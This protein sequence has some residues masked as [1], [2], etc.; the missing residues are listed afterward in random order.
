MADFY[1]GL[2]DSH[3]RPIEKRTLT[4]EIAGAVHHWRALAPLRVTGRRA[5]PEAAGV[6]AA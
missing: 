6:D 4:E 1:R 3:G 2:V 5:R